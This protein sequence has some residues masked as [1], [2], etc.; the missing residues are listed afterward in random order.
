M[1]WSRTRTLR[2]LWTHGGELRC[3]R[4]LGATFSSLVDLHGF[5]D[6][7]KG[8]YAAVVYIKVSGETAP[9]R[10]LAS[11]TRVALMKAQTIPR[12]ELCAA[13]L[14][15]E[16]IHKL[17]DGFGEQ[18]TSIRAW[19]DSTITLVWISAEP[20]RW[21]V[22]VANRVSRIQWLMPGVSWRHVSSEDNP[23]DLAS[24]GVDAAKFVT[25]NLWWEG[26]FWFS[27]PPP[28]WRT[29]PASS[30]LVCNIFQQS[31]VA[32][33]PDLHTLRTVVRCL[34]FLQL[35][36]LGCWAP[37]AVPIT[38]TELNTAFYSRV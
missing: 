24:R 32:A 17:K 28:S 16:L 7:S 26:S 15:A 25:P 35:A 10:L 27:Q 36:R 29:Q 19:S 11:K 20:S 22:F 13:T 23:E 9:A 21:E 1:N 8:A 14:L 18:V 31:Q 4:W 5:A 12:L 3:P 34:R 38:I 33:T 2:Q 30:T 6:A 37:I